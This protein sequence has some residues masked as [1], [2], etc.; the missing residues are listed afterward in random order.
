MPE[1]DLT[2]SDLLCPVGPL[3][4]GTDFELCEWRYYSRSLSA[5][6]TEKENYPYTYGLGS[7]A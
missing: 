7:K 5:Q 4:Y 1:S 2:I 6:R 3:Y